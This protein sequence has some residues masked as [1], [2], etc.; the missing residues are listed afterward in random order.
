MFRLYKPLI[1]YRK[2]FLM[3]A[4]DYENS[5]DKDKRYFNEVAKKSF[6]YPGYIRKLHSHSMG[7]DLDRGLVPYDTYW[8]MDDNKKS[9]FAVSRLRHRLNENSI[10]EGGHI[11]YDVPPSMRK[12]GY[13]TMILG[14]TLEKAAGIGL[15]RVLVTCDFDNEASDKVIVRNGG[16]FE[17]Q[18][19]S[20]YSGKMVNRY[21]IDIV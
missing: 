7:I 16:V 10:I 2:A 9:I 15:R 1:E 20:G 11:G 21:W 8:M 18:M 14:L 12:R 3:M 13:A 19:M 6:D 4:L 17:N 5:E